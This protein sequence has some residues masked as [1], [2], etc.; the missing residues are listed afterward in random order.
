M[1]HPL[2]NKAA[3]LIAC[4]FY[5]SACGTMSGKSTNV[6]ANNKS[7]LKAPKNYSAAISAAK[8]GNPR[9]AINLLTEITKKNPDFSPA[10]T[11]LGLQYLQIKKNTQAE[12]A[13]KKAIKLNP[14][15][16]TAYNHLGIILRMK[17]DFS[18]AKSMYQQAINSNSDYANAHLNL[19]ILLDM[20][21]YE[22]SDAL[23]QYKYYQ[24]LT[25]NSDKLVGKWII[26]IKRR[27]QTDTKI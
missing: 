12:D 26:D 7:S 22:L 19:G 24:S 6:D 4:I 18:D 3:I 1:F 20:Y 10:Y 2:I 13:F 5:L 25:N 8:S 9:K 11:N 16:A 17:G 23:T 14:A 21:L 27:I 15:D